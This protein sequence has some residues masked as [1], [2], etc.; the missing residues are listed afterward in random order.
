VDD[1]RHDG[2][3]RCAVAPQLIGYQPPRFASLAFQ[4]PT[5]EAFR[6]RLIATGLDKNIDYVSVLVNRARDTWGQARWK[7]R[8][9]YS[10]STVSLVG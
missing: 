2:P 6:C 9:S 7:S 8:S 4:Q 5:K 3:V 10:F 1:I